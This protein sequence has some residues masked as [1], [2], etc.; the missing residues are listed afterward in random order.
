MVKQ[1]WNIIEILK[2][3]SPRLI[4]RMERWFIDENILQLESLAY[5]QQQVQEN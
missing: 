4:L 3:T 1:K 2:P 5:S